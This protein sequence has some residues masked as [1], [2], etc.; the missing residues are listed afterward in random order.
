MRETESTIIQAAVYP[1]P[2]QGIF[3]LDL[4]NDQ[5]AVAG[6]KITVT[7]VLGNSILVLTL[8]AGVE[9]S[10]LDLS[11]QSAKDLFCDYK[12]RSR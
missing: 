10:M 4:V 3:M 6:Y 7:D 11:A 8:S 12:R 5:P 9:K 1:N 2:T